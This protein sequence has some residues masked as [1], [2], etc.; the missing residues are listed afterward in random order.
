M[1]FIAFKTNETITTE[2]HDFVSGE[3]YDYPT[4][5]ERVRKVFKVMLT[6]AFTDEEAHILQ[7]VALLPDELAA[8]VVVDSQTQQARLSQACKHDT[9]RARKTVTFSDERYDLVPEYVSR[10][11]SARRP[12]RT[13]S[14]GRPASSTRDRPQDLP[15]PCQL[16]FRLSPSPA[17]E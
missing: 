5:L 10:T 3:Q 12:A 8:R 9:A 4:A 2:H 16:P 15:F 7:D 14:I 17:L 13:V 1:P 11:S 6:R